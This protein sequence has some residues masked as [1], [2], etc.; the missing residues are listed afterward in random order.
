MVL[1]F[2]QTLNSVLVHLNE[3]LLGHY[4]VIGLF[5]Y[6]EDL[7]QLEERVWIE[8]QEPVQELIIG[9]ESDNVLNIY[10]PFECAQGSTRKFLT[11]EEHFH[12][13][14]K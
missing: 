11:L 6:E 13:P 5:F 3:C 9:A 4:V 7:H 10:P 14:N 12:N 8:L 2:I 1:T